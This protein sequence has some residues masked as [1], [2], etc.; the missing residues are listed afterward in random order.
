MSP[1]NSIG[2]KFVVTLF[3]ESH[4]KCVG[5]VIDGVPPGYDVDIDKINE[6]MA[7]RRPG[8]SKV[9]TARSE[10]DKV[11]ILSGIFNNKTTGAPIL[12]LTRN[13]DVNSSK[14]EQFKNIPRPGHA[15][16]P[17]ML[18]YGGFHDYRG[19]GRF[20]GRLT[21]GL[22]MA[23]SLARQIMIDAME[24]EIGAHV[25]EIGGIQYDGEV[26]VKD[27]RK[28]VESSI[29][30]CY[31]KNVSEKMIERI[32]EARAEKDSVGGI[33][34]CIV[35]G[36]PAGL[37]DPFFNS[38]E[39]KI[40]KLVFSIGAIKGIEF[41]IGFKVAGMKGSENNDPYRIGENGTVE[42]TSNNA[43][44]ILGG[45]STGNPIVFR[46][47]VKPTSSI[48]KKQES[49][50][51]STMKNVDLEYEGR[52]DPCIVPRVVPVIEAATC[53]VLIDIL[54]GAGLIPKKNSV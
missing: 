19:S 27:L 9:T 12:I 25:R 11:E 23:G 41:G 18:K 50:D 5:V 53:M 42:I 37:G 17:A 48:G 51:L 39:S 20:S 13:K 10:A 21:A 45:I 24:M 16:Y 4:G 43:G 52:H 15:D 38:I 14:Y 49:I 44:G 2:E 54:L 6:E 40:S 35:E 8:Q 47:V 32:E 31:E 34:E 7:R 33:V 46:V 26:N 28:K 36:L 1:H 30:R 22:V 29:V 3:G